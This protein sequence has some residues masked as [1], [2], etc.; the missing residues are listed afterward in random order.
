[1]EKPII[2]TTLSGLFIKSE[3]WN[4]AHILW[5][6]EREKEMKE[7]K[8][9]ISAIIEWRKLLQENPDEEK[10]G[11]FKFVDRVMK[12][13]YP[14]LSEEERTKKARE[15]FFDATL[16]YIQQ[17]PKVI[18]KDV[19]RYFKSIK[20]K[21]TLALIT[22]NIKPSLER[23]LKIG[24]L[25]NLFEIIE[26]SNPEEKD[27]KEAVFDR[28]IKKYDKPLIYIGSDKKDSF[29]YCNKNN[30]PCIFANFEN[31]EE[32][33]GVESAHNLKELKEKLSKLI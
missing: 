24:G 4:K 3:P 27:A 6:D 1:M 21:Y 2:A 18:N 20:N 23:I 26:T 33:I 28:F 5:Y 32:I 12:E 15:S 17:N 13:L 14:Y 8:A 22:T 7:K 25:E 9:D 30:I 31:K 11:Y 10:K 19:V 29:V 16:K